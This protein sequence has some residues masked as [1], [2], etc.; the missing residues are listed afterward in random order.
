MFALHLFLSLL[1]GILLGAF[2]FGG[3]WWTVQKMTGSG[4]PYLITTASFV[5]RVAV[6]MAVFYLLVRTDWTYLLAALIGFLTARTYLA[7]RLK[8]ITKN[9]FFNYALSLEERAG[10]RGL[11]VFPTSNI[12]QKGGRSAT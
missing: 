12:Q 9:N 5:I 2:F 10:V 7:Y 6:V 1:T 3:L 4:N 11:R 8:Q